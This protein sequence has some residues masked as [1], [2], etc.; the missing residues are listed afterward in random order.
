[1]VG[2]RKMDPASLTIQKRDRFALVPA[3]SKTERP[4][5]VIRPGAKFE[6]DGADLQTIDETGAVTGIVRIVA[7]SDA[8]VTLPVFA[9]DAT[10]EKYDITAFIARV[11]GIFVEKAA[12]AAGLFTANH[13]ITA[14]KYGAILFQMTN[15]GVIST[16][17]VATPQAYNDAASALAALPAADAG[18]LAIGYLAIHNNAGDWVANTDDLTNGSDLTTA[19]FTAYPVTARDCLSAAMAA[20]D[21]TYVEGAL[22]ATLANRRGTAVEDIVCFYTSDGT[23]ALV[24]GSLMV[25]WRPYPGAREY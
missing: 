10:P 8:I 3:V 1:M 23:G 4:F 14:N 19:A 17:V 6:V 7:Q 5:A 25:K 13:V 24:N 20:A 11:G 18:K 12:T 16:K 21:G 15:A 9:V 2:D 22:N